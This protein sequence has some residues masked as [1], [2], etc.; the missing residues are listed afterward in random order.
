M[1]GAGEG[2][3]REGEEEWPIDGCTVTRGTCGADTGVRGREVEM[4]EVDDAAFRTAGVLEE[5]AAGN[6][7]CAVNTGATR[8]AFAATS[9]E[10]GCADAVIPASAISATCTVR[11]AFVTRAHDDAVEEWSVLR[12]LRSAR[13]LGVRVSV[14]FS[15]LPEADQK[16]GKKSD[17]VCV[18]VESFGERHGSGGVA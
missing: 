2:E 4:G 6:V 5:G 11:F 18:G 16:F 1:Q 7:P 13:A 10:G 17:E 12:K 14:I 15:K 3:G 8:D 9:V